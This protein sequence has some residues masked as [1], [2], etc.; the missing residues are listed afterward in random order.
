MGVY[1][2]VYMNV[3][4][5]VHK[6][7]RAALLSM[8]ASGGLLL[9]YQSF[10]NEAKTKRGHLGSTSRDVLVSL[11]SPP[12]FLLIIQLYNHRKEYAK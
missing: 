5:N 1:T 8:G 11:Y 12:F 4:M 2:D 9:G 7:K 10:M 3:H 6:M